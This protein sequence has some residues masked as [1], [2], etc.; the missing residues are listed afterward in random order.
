MIDEVLEK[1]SVLGLDGVSR[2]GVVAGFK[3][4]KKLN[5]LENK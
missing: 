1:L 5:D 2:T 4:D 3:G